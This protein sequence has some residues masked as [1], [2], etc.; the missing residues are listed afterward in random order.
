MSDR[1]AVMNRGSIAQ[2]GT[3]RES[4][5][6][7]PVSSSA[8]FIGSSNRFGATRAR[9][10]AGRARYRPSWASSAPGSAPACPGW[11]SSADAVRSCAR[12]GVRPAAAA[13]SPCDGSVADVAVPRARGA[14]HD[15]RRAG[16]LACVAPGRSEHRASRATRFGSETGRRLARARRAP[17]WST[18]SDLRPGRALRGHRRARGRLRRDGRPRG[19][20]PRAAHVEAG[21]GAVLQPGEPRR[22]RGSARAGS[23]CCAAGCDA[24][25]AVQALVSLHGA[26]PLAP[27]RGRSTRRAATAAFFP[28]PRSSTT[29]AQEHGADCVTIGRSMS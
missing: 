26:G 19:R 5:S 24:Q 2:I 12:S 6:V 13:P 7:R 8:D 25:A 15:R 11:R 22:I 28:A 3:P 27:A 17:T 10:R 20:R 4:T 18:V 29:A 16:E 1:I 14:P 23:G 9:P 21:V